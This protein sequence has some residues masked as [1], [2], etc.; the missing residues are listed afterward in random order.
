MKRPTYIFHFATI[1]L[2]T[3]SCLLISPTHAQSGERVEC[4]T[5][6]EKVF[7]SNNETQVFLLS[8]EARESFTAFVEPVG[9]NMLF[10]MSL[11]GPTGI[12]ITSHGWVKNLSR[13]SGILSADGTYS[14]KV[15][16]GTNGVGI[17]ILSIGCDTNEGTIA[18]GDI[19]QPTPTP[20][21]L[22][23][24]TPRSA[25]PDSEP[26]FIGVGFPGL[27]PVDFSTIA[28]IPLLPDTTMTGVLP[29]GNEILGFT[30]D[31]T[32]GDT[33]DLSYTRVSGNMNLGLVVL[34]E[35]N[36]VFFQASLVTSASLATQFTL[37][38]A[39]QYTIG[40]FRISLVEPAE[41][42]PTVFQLKGTLAE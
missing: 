8:M 15:S 33:L 30:L 31:A 2:F 5:V 12:G 35:N 14:I 37:P 1:T 39:G 17:Y 36:E 9:T 34:S 3:F 32:A 10:Y 6:R 16:N 41:V 40:V 19:L 26:N 22:P 18:P 20:A 38:D 28:R 29:T 11:Y 7:V 25:I 4:G 23:T 21:P 13:S 24:P 27:A 42:E